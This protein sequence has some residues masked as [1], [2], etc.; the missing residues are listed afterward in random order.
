MDSHGGAQ[1]TN[2]QS[3]F[4]A[5]LQLDS[6]RRARIRQEDRVAV[7]I[8][9]IRQDVIFNLRTVSQGDTRITQLLGASI[10]IPGVNG[11]R[12][13][14]GVKCL[15]VGGLVGERGASCLVISDICN[16]QRSAAAGARDLTKLG[17]GHWTSSQNI[18]ICV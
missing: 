4:F 2:L 5:E 14:R 13:L 15:A 12:H 7:R 17:I 1:V 8:L 3:S 11:H 16:L 9:P 6:F 10:H 18:A